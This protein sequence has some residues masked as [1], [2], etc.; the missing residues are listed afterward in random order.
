MSTILFAGDTFF[1]IGTCGKNVTSELLEACGNFEYFCA[2]IEGPAGIDKQT[3]FPGFKLSNNQINQ[4]AAAGINVAILGNNHIY[5]HDRIGV[6]NT[7]EECEKYGLL[8][9]GA[10]K[11]G[12]DSIYNPIILHTNDGVK[13]AVF[14]AQHRYYGSSLLHQDSVGVADIWNHQ[15]ISKIIETK[16]SVDYVVFNAHC[17]LENYDIPLLTWRNYYRLLID[18]GVDIVIGHHPHVVQCH[19]KYNNK[20]IIYSLGNFAFDLD[21]KYKTLVSADWY[22][23]LVLAVFFS[24]QE[25]YKIKYISGIY[26]DGTFQ[27]NSIDDCIKE[28]ANVFDFKKYTN[29]L[30]KEFDGYVRI[31]QNAFFCTGIDYDLLHHYLA[32]DEQKIVTEEYL[33]LYNRGVIQEKKDNVFDVNIYPIIIWGFGNTGT[34]FYHFAKDHGYKI[35]GMLDSNS[36]AGEIEFE[37]DKIRCYDIESLLLIDNKTNIIIASIYE[38]EIR[39][40]I[41][42]K[43]IK[44]NVFSYNDIYIHHFSSDM[45]IWKN[46]D[47]KY[48]YFEENGI[49]Y[50]FLQDDPKSSIVLYLHGAGDCGEDGIKQ[51]SGMRN[52]GKAM[53]EYACKRKVSIYAPQCPLSER[54]IDIDYKKGEFKFEKLKN[55]M[56]VIDKVINSIKKISGGKKISLIGYSIGGFAGWYILMKYYDLIDKAILISCGGDTDY[57]FE[58]SICDKVTIVHGKKDEIIPY[59]RAD[60]MRNSTRCDLISFEGMGHDLKSQIDVKTWTEILEN[61]II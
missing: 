34:N 60:A 43:N 56:F 36:K 32:L 52:L 24:K 17:G 31:L 26:K 12:I 30:K 9:V 47:W 48:S 35:L 20:D 10:G 27:V 5:D 11:D 54:W 51:V 28:Y 38:D 44:A 3:S 21:E 8:S 1:R 39:Y 55:D 46:M 4:I 16:N 41:K 37:G 61:R 59:E 14:S 33:E 49:K 53:T 22:K 13:V 40:T 25:E 57:R 45:S 29:I 50:R 2:N 23:G 7:I 42:E 58:N 19:E 18:V 15:I 6:K